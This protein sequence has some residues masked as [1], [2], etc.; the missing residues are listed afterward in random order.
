MRVYLTAVPE[1]LRDAAQRSRLI[2]YAAYGVNPE[3]RLL[4]ESMPRSQGGLLALS[5]QHCGAVQS[6]ELLVR[7][8]WSECA[9]LGFSGVLAD[10]ERPVSTDRTQFLRQLAAFLSRNGR[11]LFVPEHYGDR[12]DQAAVVICTALSGGCLRQRLQE[13][14]QRFG[15]RLALDLQRLRMRFSLPCP[16]GEGTP[17]TAE[18][19]RRLLAAQRPTIFFSQDLC[20]KYF[21]CP[22][23][24]NACFVLFD[25]QDTL[26]K[27]CQLGRDLG[28]STGFFLY[29]EISDLPPDF[30]HAL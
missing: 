7:E 13:A 4:R 28:I 10:F 3:G 22:Q 5:D 21:V 26:R 9:S 18:E 2:A 29:P 27:K 24:G 14:Q 11:Q 20:A 1:D 30:F 12:I 17:L 16:T 15:S 19:L 23:E 6:P 25:D 8:I